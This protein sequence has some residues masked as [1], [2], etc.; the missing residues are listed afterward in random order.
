MTDLLVILNDVGNYHT[1]RAPVIEAA[2]EAG[3]D[4]EVAVPEATFDEAPDSSADFVT[5]HLDRESL[6]P[7]R[8][9]R[10][11]TSLTKLV[12]DRDPDLL[13]P[14]T[15]KPVI[16]GGIAARVAGVPAVISTITGLGW[17][18][19]SE[20]TKGQIVEKGIQRAY[21]SAFAHPNHVV[22]F[23]NRDD[24]GLFVEEGLLAADQARLVPGS[25]VDTERFQ[26]R[27]ELPEPPVIMLPSRMIYDKGVDDFVEAAR[28]CHDAGVEASFVL[29]GETD[30][31]NP[32]TISTEQ[33]REWDE[34]GPVEWWGWSDDMATTL[35]QASIVCLPTRYREGV[36]KVLLEA[37]ASGRPIVTTDAPG[38]R[39]LVEDGENGILVPPGEPRKLTET[40]TELVI[41]PS[42]QRS[43]GKRAR[44]IA[45]EEYRVE[46]VVDTTLQ[47]YRDALDEKPL[48]L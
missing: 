6:N 45:I 22:L 28:R 48:E 25:G 17:V 14:H 37:A 16:Y 27:E 40:L 26:P 46:E 43:L 2:A 34:E 18:F 9:L 15:I 31:G 13:H 12:S 32:N 30:P 11:L 8:E 33:L 35:N 4:V 5:Y 23:Q 21:R 36:P 24:Q 3:Y 47:A 42:L 38:C 41:N 19:A 20:S 10:S 29:V 1:H 39:D 44:Q 7:F